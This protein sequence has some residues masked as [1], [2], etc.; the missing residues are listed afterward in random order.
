MAD[1]KITLNTLFKLPSDSFSRQALSVGIDEEDLSS[2][3]TKV[4][5][6]VK[7]LQW[8]EIESDIFNGISELLNTDVMSVIVKTWKQ[9]DTLAEYAEQSKTTGK[10]ELVELV[11]HTMKIGLHPYLEI[12][13]AEFSKK[14]FFDVTLDLTLK[15]LQLKIE[16]AEIKSVQTGTCEGKGEIKIKDYT[17]LKL[18][19]EPIDLPGK[20]DLGSGIP[21]I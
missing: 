11:D 1:A 7:G 19:F 16:N 18:P 12:Q 21:I 3:K 13:F 10:A 8:S 20:I 6:A 5:S 14:I 2:L 17:L 15:G 9:Y 4:L